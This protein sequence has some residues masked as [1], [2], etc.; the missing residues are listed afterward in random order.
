MHIPAPYNKQTSQT[1]CQKN[2]QSASTAKVSAAFDTIT[3]R[4]HNHT[5][6]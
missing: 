4:Q 2:R 5:T 1:E 3:T 6:F